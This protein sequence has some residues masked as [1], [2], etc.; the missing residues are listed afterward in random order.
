MCID[1]TE[2]FFPEQAVMY[3]KS[4]VSK[5]R[6]E[7]ISLAGARFSTLVSRRESGEEIKLAPWMEQ[8][9]IH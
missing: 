4:Y 5:W 3:S 6:D 7:I 8:D 2:I 1:G 9:I